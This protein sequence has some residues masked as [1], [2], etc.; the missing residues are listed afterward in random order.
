M[1]YEVLE[2]IR[3]AGI[4]IPPCPKVLVDLQQVLQGHDAGTHVIERLIGRDMKLAAEVFK[5]ANSARF[6]SMK[7]F[8]SLDHAITVLGQRAISNIVRAA[9]LRASLG[10][11]DPRL[12]HLFDDVT[13]KRLNA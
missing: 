13:G 10:G 4:K 8:N 5:T 7:K 2:A 6:S 3:T 11:P 1:T 9:A 12:V